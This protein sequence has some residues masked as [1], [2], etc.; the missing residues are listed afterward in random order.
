MIG[1]LTLE[2]SSGVGVP[3]G[4]DDG[5]FGDVGE[6]AVCFQ[7]MA[8]TMRRLG[9]FRDN[10]EADSISVE[11]YLKELAEV[12]ID[13]NKACGRMCEHDNIRFI[14]MFSATRTCGAGGGRGFH[15]DIM[16]HK[17]IRNIRAVS[18]DKLFSDSGTINSPQPSDKAEGRV[19]R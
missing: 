14:A 1:F 8:R 7:T 6:A 12:T 3:P 4:L 10:V 9:E 13:L 5:G 15:R 11:K 18:G 2:M 19:R 16:E 17:I